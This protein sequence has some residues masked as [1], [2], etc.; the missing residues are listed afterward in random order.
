MEGQVDK[1]S[2]QLRLLSIFHYIFGGL[3]GLLSCI[4]LIHIVLGIIFLLF[5]DQMTSDSGQTPPAWFGWIFIIIGTFV[6]AL[7]W[8]FTIFVIT[9][10]RSLA[11][12]K[13]H[14]LCVIIGAI[15][16]IFFPLG[17]ILGVFTLIIITKPEVKELFTKP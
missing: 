11:K 5:P 14:T 7:G 2:D 1:Y 17:T 16:C 9:A 6:M 12:R 8:T 13:R 3:T 15:S 10:G 4:P